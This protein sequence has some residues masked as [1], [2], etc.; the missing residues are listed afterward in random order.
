MNQ[1]ALPSPGKSANEKERINKFEFPERNGQEAKIT[2][3]DKRKITFIQSDN[4][5]E[6]LSWP[7]RKNNQKNSTII[8]KHLKS[9]EIPID[10]PQE[11]RSNYGKAKNEETTK[12]DKLFHM[13]MDKAKQFQV[14]FPHNNQDNII[15]EVL[16]LFIRKQMSMKKGI[17]TVMKIF[18]KNK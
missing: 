16:Q 2:D 14:Y 8:M 1:V 3:R 6:D 5:N 17:S 11:V 7:R 10:D 4:K 9:E 12:N 15:D 13:D 18:D